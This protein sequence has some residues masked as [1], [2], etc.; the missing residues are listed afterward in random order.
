MKDLLEYIEKYYA[1]GLNKRE[2]EEFERKLKEDKNFRYEVKA[3]LTARKAV[4]MKADERL[5]NRLNQLG[6]VM[7]TQKK[8]RVPGQSLKMYGR[9]AIAAAIAVIV[10][11][12]FIIYLVRINNPS[13]DKLIAGYFVK[14]DPADYITRSIPD[15]PG[16]ADLLWDSVLTCLTNSQYEAAL[17]PINSLFQL[18]SEKISPSVLYFFQGYCYFETDNYEKAMKAYSS[19]ANDSQFYFDAQI[20]SSLIYLKNG[21]KLAATKILTSLKNSNYPDSAKI[22]IATELL[23][24]IDKMK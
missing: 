5:K 13:S 24:K 12:A 19:V 10:A 20:N 22:D 9:V 8:P 6:E 18:K 11:T 3:Y 1:H 7:W 2:Q 23:G 17:S 4:E 16:K 21:N 15:H 14:P